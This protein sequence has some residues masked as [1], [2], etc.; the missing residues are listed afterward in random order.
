M[1]IYTR[2]LDDLGCVPARWVR[3]NLCAVSVAVDG[4]AFFPNE[5]ENVLIDDVLGIEAYRGDL[6]TPPGWRPATMAFGR[7]QRTQFCSSVAIWT[8]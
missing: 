8:R 7:D 4:M 1:G 6:L 2:C 5:Y 3:G